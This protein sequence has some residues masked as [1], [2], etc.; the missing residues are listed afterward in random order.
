MNLK[1]NSIVILIF[2][3]FNFGGKYFQNG[4]KYPICILKNNYTTSRKYQV[5]VFFTYSEK[6]TFLAPIFFLISK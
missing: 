5:Q 2:I 6:N 3:T 4:A 1:L